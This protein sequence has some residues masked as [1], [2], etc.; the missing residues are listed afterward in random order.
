[1]QAAYDR[2]ARLQI[3]AAVLLGLVLIGIPLYLWRR[4]RSVTPPVAAEDAQVDGGVLDAAPN[5]VVITEVDAATGG[6]TLGDARVLECHDPGGKRTPPEQCDH[7]AAFEKALAAAIQQAKDCVP[8]SSGGGI[9]AYVA[10]V[11]FVR[12]RPVS[13]SLPR[14]GRSIRNTKVIQGCGAAVRRTLSELS[15]EGMAHQH[16]R[17]KVSISV[18]Y[19]AEK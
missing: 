11:S 10:D 13:L 9:V 19:P 3:L 18:T 17:Y 6:L 12:K 16:A 4:P 8:K 1:M 14:D 15:L 7:V 5:T 2:P